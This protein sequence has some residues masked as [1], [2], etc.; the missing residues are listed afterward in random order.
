LKKGELITA[1]IFIV[2]A[3][4]G[5]VDAFRLGI[6]WAADGPQAGFSVFWLASLLLVCA[7]SILVINLKKPDT[8]DKFFVGK[9][10]L[11]EVIR[12]FITATLLTVG[13]IYTGVYFATIG[14][15]LLFV[16]WI[17]KHRWA[18]VIIFTIIMTGAVYFG[19]EK[20][21]KLPLPKS[22][23]WRKGLFPI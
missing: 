19:M 15:C 10:G 3:L 17:G 1:A 22:L 8:D 23:L 13:I 4:I 11:A 12:I 6:G 18:T 14:Y 16:R 9:Q 2:V 20:G 5:L 7:V 21:L